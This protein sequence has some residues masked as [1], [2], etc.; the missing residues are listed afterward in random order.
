V[1]EKQKLAARIVVVSLVL[2]VLGDTLLRGT[3]WGINLSLWV[4]M[5][6][7][8]IAALGWRSRAFAGGGHAL[9]ALVVLLSAAFSWRDSTTLNLLSVL[10]LLIT[11]AMIMLR[12]QSG[13]IVKAFHL[14]YVLGG[15]VA[16]LNAC[17]G[18]FR[19]LIGDFPWRRVSGSGWGA[20]SLSI[21]SGVFF[22]LP[23]LLVF[24]ALL[25]AADAIFES[26]IS[27][28]LDIDFASLVTHSFLIAFFAWIAAGYLRGMMLGT[29]CDIASR[30]RQQWLSLGIVEVGIPLGLLNV[31]FL[32][33][34]LIQFRYFFGGTTSIILT[35]GLTYSEYARRGFFE[36]VTVSALVLP[37]L[38]FCH[39]ILVKDN[40]RAENIFRALAGFQ[41]VLLTVIMA[42]AYQRMRIYMNEY[43]LTEQR[44]YPTAFMAWLA[45]V[46]AWF[47]LTALRGQ[48]ERFAFGAMVAGFVLVAALHALNPDALI[49]RVNAARVSEGKKFDPWYAS[50]LS[51]DAVPELLAALPNVP[52]QDRCIVAARLLNS[53]AKPEA[54][55]WR[56]WNCSRWRAE[57][58]VRGDSARLRAMACTLN[59]RSD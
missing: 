4:L 27:K 51:A 41:I 16:A 38:L 43:G 31:L 45:V 32:S 6:G 30:V 33:F 58:M 57:R 40:P 21:A 5:L 34:V 24:G 13:A 54:D 49:A 44:L 26:I 46:F 9:L 22:S 8:F 12:A 48:R 56:T 59:S 2:G 28:I 10:A 35:P 47:A 15:F 53:W 19:L 42:S 39:W 11:F 50:N 55:D 29:E 17:L 7:G 1:D 14:D 37:L 25:V 23:I 18:G 36:L 20:R 3:P 52:Q